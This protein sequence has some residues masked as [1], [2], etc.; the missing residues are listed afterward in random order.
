[1]YKT[2]NWTYC[3]G[4]YN[5]IFFLNRALYI[6]M[7]YV[8]YKVYVI[9]NETWSKMNIKIQKLKVKVKSSLYEI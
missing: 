3:N 9:D 4:Q 6:H 2:H 1:M 5:E 8:Y 7:N